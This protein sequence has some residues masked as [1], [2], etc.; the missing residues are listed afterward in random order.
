MTNT[1]NNVQLQPPNTEWTEEQWTTFRNWIVSHLQAGPVT[2]TF[3]KKDGAERVM[4][5]SLQPELL[6]PSPIKESTTTKKENPNIISVYD[7][8]AQGWRSFIVKN[9]TNVTLKI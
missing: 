9:V 8:E 4:T 3:N 6:P 7:L 1:S 2:V 5:C